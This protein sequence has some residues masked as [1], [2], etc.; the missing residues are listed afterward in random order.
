MYKIECIDIE[1]CDHCF[2]LPCVCTIVNINIYGYKG[3]IFITT[4]LLNTL[5]G[6]MKVYILLNIV[7][8]RVVKK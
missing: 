5:Y 8:V 6:C 3:E 7:V 2:T 4:Y 1:P